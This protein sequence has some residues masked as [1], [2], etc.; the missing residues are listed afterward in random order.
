MTRCSGCGEK[1]NKPTGFGCLT[2]LRNLGPAAMSL[3]PG[4]ERQSPQY[5]K[6]L[7]EE[8][9]KLRLG[10]QQQDTPGAG[11]EVNGAVGGVPPEGGKSNI[12][13]ILPVLSDIA[14]QLQGLPAVLRHVAQTAPSLATSTTPTAPPTVNNPGTSSSATSASTM[15]PQL[16]GQIVP[17]QTDSGRMLH[18]EIYIA[19]KKLTIP[20]EHVDLKGFDRKTV[21]LHDFVYGC[22]KVLL[23]MQ[24]GG[25]PRLPSYIRHL[26]HIFSRLQSKRYG[27]KG[28]LEYNMEIVSEIIMGERQDFSVDPIVSGLHF[29]ANKFFSEEFNSKGKGG[30][31]PGAR[32]KEGPSTG[33]NT[34]IT[35]PSDFPADICYYFNY[36]NCKNQNCGKKHVCRKCSGK[37][38]SAG[39]YESRD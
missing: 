37:H 38:R 8:I 33:K 29:T 17:P 1:H 24:N 35:V 3:Y 13:D 21:D 39:C 5:L 7:E 27:I 16:S 20:L 31:A 11:S 6:K 26:D 2:R 22:I 30:Q 10:Q 23:A 28:A 34:S 4:I 18:P 32:R 9:A 19:A 14:T 36:H 12:S 25:D 15:C